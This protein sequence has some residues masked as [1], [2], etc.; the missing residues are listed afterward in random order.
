[1]EERDIGI[2]LNDVSSDKVKD[3]NTQFC[4]WKNKKRYIIIAFISLIIIFFIMEIIV[5]FIPSKS[6]SEEKKT[7]KGEINCIYFIDTISHNINILGKE[8]IK[9]SVIDIFINNKKIH[10][11]NEYKFSKIGENN[12]NF[13]IYEDISLTICLKI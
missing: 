11:S 12:I 10:F 1:M 8:F 3:G 9:T 4:T 2:I 13:I 7:K 5:A 6:S